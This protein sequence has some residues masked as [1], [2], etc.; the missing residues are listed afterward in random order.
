MR[1][2]A[3]AELRNCL[4]PLYLESV[5]NLIILHATRYYIHIAHCGEDKGSYCC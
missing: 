5:D 3:G 1:E 2:N 4:I